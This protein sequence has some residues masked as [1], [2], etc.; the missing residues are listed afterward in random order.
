MNTAFDHFKYEIFI[1]QLFTWYNQDLF[2]FSTVR[3]SLYGF[4]FLKEKYKYKQNLLSLMI[5][6]NSKQRQPLACTLHEALYRLIM[7]TSNFQSGDQ[8]F[9]PC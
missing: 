1:P 4:I 8:A 7:K 5:L 2:N 3:M 6:A 9:D